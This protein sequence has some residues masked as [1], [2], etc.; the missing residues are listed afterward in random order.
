VSSESKNSGFGPV[1]LAMVV[2]NIKHLVLF[3]VVRGLLKWDDFIGPKGII[4][5]FMTLIEIALFC[6]RIYPIQVLNPV[7]FCEIQV[8]FVGQL[9]ILAFI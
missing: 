2:T 5:A 1:F 6:L 4:N 9:A 3:G 7:D 8:E